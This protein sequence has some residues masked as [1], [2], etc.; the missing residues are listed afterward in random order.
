M[1]LLFIFLVLAL[2]SF[3]VAKLDASIENRY[4]RTLVAVPS[5]SVALVFGW[6]IPA[7][8]FI[9]IAT[10]NGGSIIPPISSMGTV[11]RIALTACLPA[12]F[13]RLVWDFVRPV[14]IK[15]RYE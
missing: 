10:G 8:I 9:L 4:L 14:K 13:L 15:G 1:S 3:I 7:E 5:A 11:G 12:L 6:F 2:A